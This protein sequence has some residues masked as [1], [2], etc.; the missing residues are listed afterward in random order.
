MRS[1][2]V[3]RRR[4]GP[5]RRRRLLALAALT[6]VVV[7]FAWVILGSGGSSG[8]G[9]SG[10]VTGA[11]G[12]SAGGASSS[13]GARTTHR[14]PATVPLPVTGIPVG[15]WVDL[16]A[17]PSSRGEVSAA[18]LGDNVY[19]VG[20]FDTAGQTTAEVQRLDLRTERWSPVRRMPKALNHMSAFAYQ[21]QLYVV[22][23]YASPGDTSTD[24]VQGF[25]RYDPRTG[26][27]RAMPDAPIP[28]AAAGA[29]VLGHR[30]YVVGGRNDVT[31]ALSSTAIFDFDTGRWSLGPSLAHAREHL[32]VVAAGGSIWALGGRE[33]G[34]S[35]TY[36]E[37]YRPGAAAWQSMP[38]MPVARSGFQAVSVGDAIV[39]VGGEDG[40][41][42]V[43]E[44]D[45]L[46]LRTGR[47]TPLADLPVARHGLGVVADGP[48]RV[49]DRWRP[50]AGP[51][52]LA[53][54]HAPTRSVTARP[55]RAAASVSAGSRYGR[56]S[57]VPAAARRTG[58]GVRR[59][60][61]L[62]PAAA[63]S[64]CRSRTR[65]CCIGR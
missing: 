53:A 52:D 8:S 54:G 28:R 55:A 46:D 65:R 39:V 21:G 16:P 19:V 58:R 2:R 47:W 10:H 34:I 38:S 6:T 50:A 29:A 31:A 25:W 22:G 64:G 62:R 59:R 13:G 11:A 3:S 1:G 14:A 48:L 37:R 23:G 4:A 20:G 35:N 41:S 63:R 24:A 9:A 57:T 60:P 44:V 43:P 15:T 40:A 45:R 33:L 61:G 36:V 56:V 12:S 5:Y 17:A 7:V 18:R 49:R 42:T 27:W 32:A 26:H 30:L 51:D